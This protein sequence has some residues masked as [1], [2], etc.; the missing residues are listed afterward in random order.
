MQTESNSETC[1]IYNGPS[2]LAKKVEK[3]G[4]F[5]LPGFFAREAVIAAR[6]EVEALLDVSEQKHLKYKEADPKDRLGM[7]DKTTEYT[8]NYEDN[9]HTQFFFS[10]R[11][12][13]Y[14]KLLND[15]F[16]SKV[17]KDLIYELA[18]SMRLRVDLCQRAKGYDDSTGQPFQGPLP[19][20]RDT[21]GEFTFGV[22]LDDNPNPGWGGTVFIPGSH[23]NPL[24]PRWDLIA[25]EKD[26]F[27]YLDLYG[28]KGLRHLPNKAIKLA[29]ANSMLRKK[30]APKVVEACGMMGDIYFFLNDTWHGRAA[31]ITGKRNMASRFGGFS[32]NFAFKDDIILPEATKDLPEPLR[33]M[34]L[35]PWDVNNPD[36][37]INKIN[38]RRPPALIYKVAA[39]EKKIIVGTL[40]AVKLRKDGK[41]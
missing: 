33:S 10:S 9:L 7:I 31:N 34:Y 8:S 41:K 1:V 24:N 17:I 12:P 30:L 11:S 39:K 28:V 36:A 20:H 21:P 18:G 15:L 19:W 4:Y 25:G 6:K 27:T 37:I 40:K 22:F 23:W 14:C 16:A 38:K 5:V 2:D 26:I 32:T 29:K 35:G 3:D 13:A